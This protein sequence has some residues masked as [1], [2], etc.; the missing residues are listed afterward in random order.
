MSRIRGDNLAPEMSLRSALR[1]LGIKFRRNSKS[2]PGKPDLF[3]PPA[4][5]A[6]LV[7]GCFF[8]GCPAHFRLPKSNRKFWSEKIAANGRRDRRVAKKLN[9]LGLSVKTVWEH[10]VR[11]DPSGVAEQ[12]ARLV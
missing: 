10:S 7:H 2:L 3:F 4:N 1:K 11:R 9:G 12:I 8:H 6:V 5:L